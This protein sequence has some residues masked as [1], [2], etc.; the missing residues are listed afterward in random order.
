MKSDAQ[1]IHDALAVF[2][3]KAK[4]LVALT[5]KDADRFMDE[6]ERA[7]YQGDPDTVGIAAHSLK[8]ILKQI[9]A[10]SAAEVA[11]AMETSGKAND[12][13]RCGEA[14]PQL[15]ALYAATRETLATFAG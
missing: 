9:G 8:S 13:K 1:S 7:F 15:Q 14:L 6:I 11:F 5:L 10:E 3:A 4:T 12:L 2:G